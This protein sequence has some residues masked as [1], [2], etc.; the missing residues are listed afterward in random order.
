M[1]LKHKKDNT[2]LRKIAMKPVLRLL[3]ILLISIATI[4]TAIAE[5]DT[6]KT[7]QKFCDIMKKCTLEQMEEEEMPAS[8]KDM[9]MQTINLQCESM[10]NIPTYAENAY[11]EIVKSANACLNS[12]ADNEC[13]MLEGE[14][15]TPEC[16][17]F[18]KQR[19]N[20]E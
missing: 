16:I 13:A 1:L 2:M 11:P 6:Q 17:E 10:Y 20:I 7:M 4:P 18:E 9:V 3:P 14:L 8:V 5:T 19:S 15:D 12:L